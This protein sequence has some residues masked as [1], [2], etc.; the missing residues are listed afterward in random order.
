M[1]PITTPLAFVAMQ[2]STWHRPINKGTGRSAVPERQSQGRVARTLGFTTP[3]KGTNV[4]RVP[5]HARG[6]RLQ[7]IRSEAPVV[8]A[9][10]LAAALSLLWIGRKSLWI[11][12]TSS[13][14]YA[15]DWS[16]MWHELLHHEANMWLYYILLHFWLKLGDSE[17]FLRSLS[18]LFAVA[19]VLLLC[20]LGRR[21]FDRRAGVIAGVL[22]AA[23]PFFVHYAQEVRGYTLGVCLVTLS[24]YL[25]VLA[26]EG[27]AYA[28]WIAWAAATALGIYTHFFA[29]L[30]CLVQLLSLPL[31]GR[32]NLPWRG[33]VLALAAL[34]LFLLPLV[35]FE[36]LG[37]D[38]IGWIQRPWSWRVIVDFY[39]LAAGS[40]LLLALYALFGAVTI[41]L[42]ARRSAP[43]TCPPICW[44]HLYVMAWAVLPVLI[45][46]V[47]SRKVKPIFEARYLIIVVPALALLGGACVARLPRA[48][49]RC[50]AVAA[51]LYLSARCLYWYYTDYDKE[52][53][54]DASAWVLARARPG[55][56]AIFYWWSGREAFHYYLHRAGPGAPQVNLPDLTTQ[57]ENR[58]NPRYRLDPKRLERVAALYPR[59]WI[60]LRGDSG[61]GDCQAMLK[62]LETHYRC[63]A[64][65]GFPYVS[66]RLFEK[67]AGREPFEFL[68]PMP[69]TDLAE[70][71]RSVAGGTTSP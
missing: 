21:L 25:F 29:A 47:F 15:Y 10:A 27:R 19:T 66:V 4:N 38:Q 46:F 69:S 8:A 67:P 70:G 35:L 7:A 48:W 12:E 6:R 65:E 42:G 49:L 58:D 5:L 11:D 31:L 61:G 16:A 52:N 9:T 41:L 2:E 63:T 20:L 23:N 34:A 22:L 44:R 33:V 17:A 50:L 43:G 26:L 59:V 60:F 14:F 71:F 30:V 54:R 64:E 3:G 28:L 57:A 1:R 68:P 51:L 45:T 39:R 62:T 36:P 55:D 40:R 18:A 13:I 24:S 37:S 32:R 56:A 53:W